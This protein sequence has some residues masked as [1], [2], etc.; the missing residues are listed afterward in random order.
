MGLLDKIKA[1]AQA[2]SESK[3]EFFYTKDGDKRRI[4]MLCEVDD[5]F[6]VIFHSSYESKINVPCQKQFG[7]ECAYCGNHGIADMKEKT[8]YVFP[9][10]GYDEGKQQILM[11]TAYKSFSAIMPL[12]EEAEE[13]GT[14]TDRD[15][16]VKHVGKSLDKTISVRGQKPCKMEQ[17]L[18]VWTKA[19]MMEKIDKAHPYK[20]NL[21]IIADESDTAD[22]DLPF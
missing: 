20:I 14:I 6:E 22:G 19:E 15:Y 11:G 16:V 13:E 2:S 18:T 5:G 21:D 12:V 4:R 7:R 10:Y 3:G 1:S 17:K 9:V 8:Q